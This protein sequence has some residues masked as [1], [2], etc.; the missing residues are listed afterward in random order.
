[1]VAFKKY[2]IVF[3]GF[4]DNLRESKYFNDVYSFDLE[5]RVWAKLSTSGSEPSPRY[6]WAPGPASYNDFGGAPCISNNNFGTENVK[7]NY[8]GLRPRTVRNAALLSP[9]S[10]CQLFPSLDGRLVVY[11]GY[12]K[13]KG[14][15]G[16]EL[17]VTHQDM[18]LLSQDRHDESGTK[19]RWQ[20]VKQVGLQTSTTLTSGRLE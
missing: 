5:N 20:A 17:G 3:G 11:G 6:T 13:Q 10:A 15:K 2:L 19:W 18:F 16:K 9:R 14:K 8:E 4:H 7:Q 12:C 1:M